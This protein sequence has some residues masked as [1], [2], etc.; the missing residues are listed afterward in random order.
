MQHS[1]RCV[2]ICDIQMLVFMPF[3]YLLGEGYMIDVSYLLMFIL[4]A[5]DHFS[6][7]Q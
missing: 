7:R 1:G 6:S 3:G 5:K 4:A 2:G